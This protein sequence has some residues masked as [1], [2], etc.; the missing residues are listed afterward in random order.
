MKN[1]R[2][3]TLVEMLATIVIFTIIS[4]FIFNVFISSNKQYT[5]QVDNQDQLFDLTY[6]LKLVTKDI[7]KSTSFE[8]STMKFS[9]LKAVKF[10]YEYNQSTKTVSRIEYTNSGL[11][12]KAVIANNIS[13]FELIYNTSK[14]SILF[15]LTN[16]NGQKIENTLYFR[17]D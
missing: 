6:A 4:L 12:N 3:F 2:G 7:R 10:Q 16:S 17:G 9:V 5:Q 8:Q 1:Q 13:Q 15:K 14:D 11:P